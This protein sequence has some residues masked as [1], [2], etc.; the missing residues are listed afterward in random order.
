MIRT[1]SLL[2]M[3]SLL[4]ASLAGAAEKKSDTTAA[5]NAIIADCQTTAAVGVELLK[6]KGK[7]SPEEMLT[8][9]RKMLTDRKYQGSFG[10]LEFAANMYTSMTLQPNAEMDRFVAHASPELLAEMQEQNEIACI[11]NAF[12]AR[13]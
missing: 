11:N 10:D 5:D 7:K 6:M 2:V 4:L 3:A 1:I 8:A 12:G 13:Q 9:A